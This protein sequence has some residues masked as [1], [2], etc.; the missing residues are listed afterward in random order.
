MVEWSMPFIPAL[1]AAARFS[2][3]AFRLAVAA[4]VLP[5]A[6]G[7]AAGFF[8]AG[9]GIVM[10]GMFIP[11]IDWAAAGAERPNMEVAVS[12]EISRFMRPLLQAAER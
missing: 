3:A 4:F 2:G 10:P 11:C 6:T 8:L 12:A 5:L 9:I 1:G 7:F